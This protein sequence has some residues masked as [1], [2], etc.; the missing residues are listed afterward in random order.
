M[1]TIKK[2]KLQGIFKLR[3]SKTLYFLK[4]NQELRNHLIQNTMFLS[5]TNWS[6]EKSVTLGWLHKALPEFHRQGDLKAELSEIINLPDNTFTLVPHKHT[7]TTPNGQRVIFN[8]LN[9]SAWKA[10][11]SQQK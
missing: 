10:K 5:C 8:S 9:W 11:L 7:L 4:Q 2:N 1:L 3:S 6:T